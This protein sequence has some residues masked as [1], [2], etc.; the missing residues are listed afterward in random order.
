MFRRIPFII[1]SKRIKTGINLKYKTY[2]EKKEKT[3]KK[4]KKA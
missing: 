3:F 2:T 1:V 4:L